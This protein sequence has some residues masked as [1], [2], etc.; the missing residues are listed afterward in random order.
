LNVQRPTGARATSSRRR[1][2]FHLTKLG[3]AQFCV[4]GSFVA[5]V[6]C[7]SPDKTGAVR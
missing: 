7:F 4:F 6:R 1:G 5:L 3:L 2:V